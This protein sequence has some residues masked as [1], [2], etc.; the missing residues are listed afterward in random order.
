MNPFFPPRSRS[1]ASLFRGLIFTCLCLWIHPLLWA[2]ARAS[3]HKQ[4]RKWCGSTPPPA[5]FIN[6]KGVA[7]KRPDLPPVLLL[8]KNFLFNSA[9]LCSSPLF[10]PGPRTLSQEKHSHSIF[11]A[12]LA[13]CSATM[14][15]LQH[16]FIWLALFIN[17]HGRRLLTLAS[18]LADFP[19]HSSADLHLEEVSWLIEASDEKLQ[20]APGWKVASEIFVNAEPYFVG[21]Y[22][23]FAM[24]KSSEGN[25]HLDIHQF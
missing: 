14:W 19:L 6:D 20:L 2:R 21:L 22:S 1:I 4:C 25:R 3:E 16:L 10:L 8:I 18:D 7:R 23:Y 5:L 9:P 17:P 12:L 24:G 11:F 15:S 13:F